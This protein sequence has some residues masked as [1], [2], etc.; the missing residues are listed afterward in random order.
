MKNPRHESGMALT[1]RIWRESDITRRALAKVQRDKDTA[2]R[3]QRDRDITRLILEGSTHEAAAH[4]HGVTRQRAR[5][6]FFK[7]IMRL[8]YKREHVK[9]LRA[10]SREILDKLCNGV[11]LT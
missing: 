7:T 11:H 6:I 5:Q 9:T 10:K 2:R 4:A 8:G 1:R 3:V